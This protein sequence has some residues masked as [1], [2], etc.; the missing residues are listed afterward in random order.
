MRPH[1]LLLTTAL[2]LGFGQPGLAADWDA[3]VHAGNQ[4]ATGWSTAAIFRTPASCGTTRS[5]P[6]TLKI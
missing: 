3:L 2:A 1:G 6:I 4:S 5:T